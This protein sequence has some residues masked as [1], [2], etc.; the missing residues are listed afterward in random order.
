MVDGNDPAAGNRSV[1]VNPKGTQ[2]K[3]YIVVEIYMQRSEV[4]DKKF[5]ER[6]GKK[7]KMLQEIATRELEAHTIEDLQKPTTKEYIRRTLQKKFN[8]VLEGKGYS[9]PVGK[10][11][12]SKWIIQ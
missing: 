1:V 5:K 10:I 8:G 9:T 12:F 4:K 3:R 6:A 11:V 7:T 2:G